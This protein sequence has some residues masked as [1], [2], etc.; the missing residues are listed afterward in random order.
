MSFT[1]LLEIIERFGL[2]PE[3][4]DKKTT[5]EI[6]EEMRKDTELKP[7]AR[8]SWTAAPGAHLG[9]DRLHPR[10]PGQ[11]RRQGPAG[12]QHPDLALS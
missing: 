4:G 3:L 2:Y 9:H 6:V 12:G 8:I 10:L 11:G 1:R 5:E 7:S